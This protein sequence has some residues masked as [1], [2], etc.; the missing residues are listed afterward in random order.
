[1]KTIKGDLLDI[2]EGIICHQVNC[3]RVAGAGLA[4]QIR[5]KWPGWYDAFLEQ[6]PKLG[7]CWLLQTYTTKRSSWIA[8]L[9]AQEFYGSGLQTSYSAFERALSSLQEMQNMDL[10]GSRFGPHQVYVPR[11]I[12]CGLAGGD[13]NVIEPLIERYFP[14]AILVEK[15]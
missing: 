8:S 10:N 15:P 13:W 4:L 14:N 2:T 3:Q 12:G 9:Y 1:M 5:K 7:K 6:P 11:G